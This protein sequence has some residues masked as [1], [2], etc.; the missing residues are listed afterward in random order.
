MSR[1]YLSPDALSADPPAA[2]VYCTG[3]DQ[4]WNSGTNGFVEGPFYLDFAP[5]GKPRIAFSAS[6]GRPRLPAE[7]MDEIRPRLRGYAGIGVRESSGV[8]VLK[9]LGV[10]ECACTLD[11]TLALPPDKW[12]ELAARGEMP[13]LPQRYILVYQFNKDPLI[14]DIAD[15]LAAE[16]GFKVVKIF[17]FR[18]GK[19]RQSQIKVLA[20]E[21]ESFLWLVQHASFVVTNSFHALAFSSVFRK[22]FAAVYPK[23][24]GVRLDDY[25]ELVGLKSRHFIPGES[26]LADVLSDIDYDRVDGIL[27]EKRT[28]TLAYV[29]KMLRA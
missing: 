14:D 21:V 1:P 27:R 28:E 9:A 20:P 19:P 22:R 5:P 10:R 6:F 16:T 15:R 26:G 8:S 25:L 13:G 2:D 24:Y 4:V 17:F 29:E 11:P 3:S 18:H 12:R 23:D 7:E